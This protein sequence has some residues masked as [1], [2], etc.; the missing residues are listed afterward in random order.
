MRTYKAG[1]KAKFIQ[2]EKQGKDAEVLD[3]LR[4]RKSSSSCR[5][6]RPLDW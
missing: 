4:T 3:T 2:K 5:T 6:P 1:S